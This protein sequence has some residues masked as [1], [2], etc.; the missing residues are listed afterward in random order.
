MLSVEARDIK[1]E[2]SGKSD[3]M[4]WR[5]GL[6]VFVCYTLLRL[7][8]DDWSFSLFYLHMTGAFSFWVG[9]GGIFICGIGCIVVLSKNSA[10]QCSSATQRG[11]GEHSDRL[12]RGIV[13]FIACCV[14]L[15]VGLSNYDPSAVFDSMIRM[16]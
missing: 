2:E 10:E 15:V 11:S 3:E 13:V 6:L 9:L 1:N 14:I 12:G 4:L 16:D 8:R 5:L 7:W